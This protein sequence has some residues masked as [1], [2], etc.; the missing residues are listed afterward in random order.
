MRRGGDHAIH[1]IP[2][3]SLSP[4]YVRIGILVDGETRGRVLYEDIRH[5]YPD[6]R[7]IVFYRIVHPGGDEMTPPRRC[8]DA[9]F[10]LMPPG[11]GRRRRRRRIVRLFGH[12]DGRSSSGGGGGGGIDPPLSVAGG[13][14]RE[15][16]G[17]FVGRTPSSRGG[18]SVLGGKLPMI[19][20]AC[21]R[22]D[23]CERE[24]G[25]DEEQ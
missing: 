4:E 24:G 21:G 8:G 14:G 18:R 15:E 17:E 10:V 16:G 5:P 25:R 6:I 13:G 3:L 9:D 11:N 2:S 23:E 22:E 20:G 12:D 1:I 7:Y 19:D